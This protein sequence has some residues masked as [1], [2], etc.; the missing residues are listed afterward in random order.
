MATSIAGAAL[1][2]GNESLS[3]FSDAL[4]SLLGAS[5]G[6]PP[7]AGTPL[8]LAPLDTPLGP[9]LL[10]A[11]AGT[12]CLAEFADR[13]PGRLEAQL[14]R[15][16]RRLKAVLVPGRTPP[17]ERAAQQLAEYFA[18]ARQRFELPLPT[19]GT[20]LQREVWGSLQQIPYGETRS[21]GR[22]AA[23]VGR[24]RAARP[25]GR[26]VGANPIAIVVPC[27]RVIGSGGALTGYGGGLWRKRRLLDLERK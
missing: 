11:A 2:G 24:P 23:A 18:G 10:G 8:T 22:V 4:R 15:V 14:Q 3:G 9:M 1:A 16:R 12:L 13:E 25:V 27:H 5:P 6:A 7:G 26:A 19:S 17:I 20:A 21:Y